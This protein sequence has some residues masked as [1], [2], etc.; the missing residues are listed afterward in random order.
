MLLARFD[1]CGV[2]IMNVMLLKT[3]DHQF[4]DSVKSFNCFSVSQSAIQLPMQ[5]VSCSKALKKK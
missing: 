2:D 5:N 4:A 1:M 3:I